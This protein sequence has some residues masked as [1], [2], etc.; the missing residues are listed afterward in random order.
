MLRPLNVLLGF[1]FD[2]H[3][4]PLL[5]DT[6]RMQSLLQYRR[7]GLA[8]HAQVQRDLE[9]ANRLTIRPPRSSLSQS[10]GEQRDNAEKEEEEGGRLTPGD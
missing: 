4:L 5:Q 2:R 3:Q 8:A 9:Q 6:C 1:P 7:I 10:D